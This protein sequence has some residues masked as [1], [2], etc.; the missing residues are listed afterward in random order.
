MIVIEQQ[1]H[2]RLDA[3]ESD[4]YDGTML[5]WFRS[6]RVPNNKKAYIMRAIGIKFV[7]AWVFL[8]TLIIISSRGKT[9]GEQVRD[10]VVQPVKLIAL[11]EASSLQ[12]ARYPLVLDVAK[13]SDLSFQVGGLI[14]DLAVA[15][16]Q[17]VREGHVIASRR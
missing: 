3:Q 7:L 6:A 11:A 10:S 14:A 8:T 2:V 5:F 9:D 13:S 4:S 15:D 16:S 12:I 17:E 1:P